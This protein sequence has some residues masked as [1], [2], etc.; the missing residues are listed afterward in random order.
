MKL[1]RAAMDESPDRPKRAVGEL[2][3]IATHATRS[4]GPPTMGGSRHR[5]GRG[6]VLWLAGL[7]LRALCNA[8]REPA[9]LVA[10]LRAGHR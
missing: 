1:R 4:G 3:G 5:L 7:P 6:D 2:Q 9:V 8:V 10:V